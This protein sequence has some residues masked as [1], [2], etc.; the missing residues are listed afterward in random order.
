MKKT[1]AWLILFALLLSLSAV[2]AYA[3]NDTLTVQ[4]RSGSYTFQVGDSFTYQYWLNLSPDI[5]AA[6]GYS[7][8]ATL[9][10]LGDA[11]LNEVSGNIMFDTSHLEVVDKAMPQFKE[12]EESILP[13]SIPH[14]V[15]YV[16]NDVLGGTA[17]DGTVLDFT[18][19]DIFFKA[20]FIDE[21]EELAFCETNVLVSV[22]FRVTDGS[23]TPVYMRTK[24]KKLNATYGS[25]EIA[26]IDNKNSIA[27]VPF[28]S[29]ETV[30]DAQPQK[31]LDPYVG[32][33]GFDIRCCLTAGD[34]EHYLRPGP[35]VAVTLNGVTKFGE[36]LEM[37]Q[38]SSGDPVCWF[39]DIPYGEYFVSCSYVSDAGTKYGTP[40]LSKGEYV[41]I[42][43]TGIVQALWLFEITPMT[44]ALPDYPDM[45]GPVCAYADGKAV[46]FSNGTVTLDSYDYRTL[47]VCTFN[48]NDPDVHKNYPQHMYVWTLVYAN[49]EYSA[50]RQTSLDD[51]LQYAGSSIRITGRKGIR[52]ITGI[53]ETTRKALIGNANGFRLQEYGTL[54]A[55]KDTLGDRSLTLDVD[56]AKSTYAYKRAVADPIYRRANGVVQYTNVLV[57]FS[58]EQ[59]VPELVMRPYMTVTD[60]L[61]EELTIYGGPVT[62][63]IGYIAYQNR[64]A[65]TPGSSSYEYIWGIIHT[66]YGDTYDVDYKG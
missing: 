26:F 52:M 60:A 28:A 18:D 48:G 42:P 16:K 54:V 7:E 27:I 41:S 21:E 51:V 12:K 66:V 59:C 19:G 9:S 8:A 20:L 63:S 55:W 23:D 46:P 61:G 11:V 65:F 40:K 14:G 49:D 4:T 37:T 35:G 10:I 39:Y 31:L 62:R 22:T 17:L 6:L 29:Y 44:F 34:T 3:D 53:P 5:L 33:Q 58:D 56:G 47:V 1:A 36:P 24:I 45:D 38:Y 25:K 57:G 2:P 50:I 15:V 32:D 64:A 43:S 13:I 30:N